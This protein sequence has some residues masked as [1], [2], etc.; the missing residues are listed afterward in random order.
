M[1]LPTT[2]IPSNYVS[3]GLDLICFHNKAVFK[4]VRCHDE[5]GIFYRYVFGSAEYRKFRA[6][7]D[8]IQNKW[9]EK[10]TGMNYRSSQKYFMTK[11]K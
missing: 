6:K 8:L 11:T 2:K 10:C 5:A 7:T 1:Q 4:D 9:C 3:N